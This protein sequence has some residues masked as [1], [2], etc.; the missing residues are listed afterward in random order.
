MKKFLFGLLC[1]A[2]LALVIFIVMTVWNKVLP[3]VIHVETINFWQ[4]AGIFLLCKILFG[5]GGMGRFG[6][7][8]MHFRARMEEKIKDMSPEERERFKNRFSGRMFACYQEMNKNQE[9][10][11]DVNQA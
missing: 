10:N 1:L 8:K 4:A 9:S 5:F 7:N 2:F 3:D 11:P 6:R